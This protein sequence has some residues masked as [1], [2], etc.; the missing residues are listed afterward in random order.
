MKVS[1]IIFVVVILTV[2]AGLVFLSTWNIPAPA[3]QVEKVIPNE[4]LSR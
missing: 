2:V 1:I 3:D 4:K